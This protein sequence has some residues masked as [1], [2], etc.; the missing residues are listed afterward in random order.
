MSK[1]KSFLP[2][3]LAVLVLLIYASTFVVN[4]WQTAIKLQLG[5]IVGSDYAPG[6]H[7]KVPILQDVKIFDRRIQTLDAP[8]QR[9]LTVEKKDV[10][11]DSYAK[12]R[13]SDPAQYFRS[14]GGNVSRTSRLLAER[15]GSSLRDEFG[16]R[17]I[18]EVVSEDRTELMEELRKRSDLQANEL[19]VE[20]VDVRVKKIDLPPE[21]SES[22]Y[23]RMRAERERVA[24]DLRAKGKEAAERIR[25]DADR[26]RTVMLAD[27][28][29]E[30]EQ[31]RG[32]GDAKA[33]EIYAKAYTEDA[34]FY[35]FYRS[36]GAYR[37]AFHSGGDMMVLQ[38]ESEFFRYFRSQSGEAP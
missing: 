10:I 12:W 15:I 14:T 11:V 13:I 28:Y 33:T 6:L 38:P 9:F 36:L 18:Q 3:L 24:S 21:V 20:I 34:D 25:A 2:A 8:P 17:T 30:S 1:Y 32:E 35:A 29:K 23:M 31:A 37:G 27:A 16:K 7:F 5:S 19:G 4:E 26:Q 22:V